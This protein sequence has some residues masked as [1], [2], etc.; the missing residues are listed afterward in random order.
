[1]IV[2]GKI[3]AR[4]RKTALQK[5]LSTYVKRLQLGIIV[6]H[7]TLA[8][9][10]F[11]DLKKRFGAEVGVDVVETVLDPLADTEKLLQELLH[12][13]RTAD[14]LVLQLPLPQSMELA[15]VLRLFPLSHDVDVLGT[16]A[17]EQYKE[18][19]LP[20]MPPVV[21]A[22]DEILRHYSHRLAGKNVTIFG[23]GRLVGLPASIWAERSGAKVTVVNQ[24]TPDVGDVARSADVLILGAG[25]P[26]LITQ[27]MVRDGAV[28]LDAG[29]SEEGGVLKG[30]ADPACAE[31]VALFTPTPGGIGPITV[32]KIFENL[33][34]LHKLRSRSSETKRNLS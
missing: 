5:E 11:V 31:K 21:A 16:V 32:V 27:D 22:M 13:T 14:G 6:A 19:H 34:A 4:A 10:K 24:D 30:D 33:L 2:D 9:R 12:A 25:I 18:G 23:S 20:I 8:I 29:T 17:F 15:T 7:E 1:M 26:G 3:I 28:I